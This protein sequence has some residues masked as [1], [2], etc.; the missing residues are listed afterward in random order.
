MDFVLLGDVVK[1]QHEQMFIEDEEDERDAKVYYESI[2][3]VG[4]KASEAGKELADNPHENNTPEYESW[5]EGF[6]SYVEYV[7]DPDDFD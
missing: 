3:H 4:W 1:S 6:Y 2:M 7:Q 5:N